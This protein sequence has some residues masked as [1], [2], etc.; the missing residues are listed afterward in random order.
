MHQGI[1]VSAQLRDGRRSNTV[2]IVRDVTKITSVI[3]ADLPVEE[4]D[5]FGFGF[6]C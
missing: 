4:G 6:C 2:V 5:P 3:A 1:Q